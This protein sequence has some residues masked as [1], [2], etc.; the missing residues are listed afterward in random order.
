MMRS[1]KKVTIIWMPNQALTHRALLSK[2]FL[3]PKVD[4]IW[5][6]SDRKHSEEGSGVYSSAQNPQSHTSNTENS[7]YHPCQQYPL[8][9]A[10]CCCSRIENLLPLT[11]ANARHQHSMIYANFTGKQELL[12]VTV[13]KP[14]ANFA[15]RNACT[16]VVVSL[17]WMS[18][19]FTQFHA[20]KILW[21][22]F[23]SSR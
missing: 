3:Q 4:L 17:K 8:H 14:Q 22:T 9:T 18:K 13:Q 5:F 20:V 1:K 7:V 2:S 16:T 23:V 12:K 19:E 15:E 21:P 6:L 10:F 11:S